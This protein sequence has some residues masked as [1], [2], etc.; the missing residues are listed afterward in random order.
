V[1]VR[2]APFGLSLRVEDTAGGG[3]SIRLPKNLSAL[4]KAGLSRVPARRRVP[5]QRDARFSACLKRILLKQ[6]APPALSS[7]LSS[8]RREPVEWAW[9]FARIC[10]GTRGG[11]LNPCGR[12]FSRGVTARLAGAWRSRSTPRAHFVAADVSAASELLLS[13]HGFS[14]RGAGATRRIRSRV[15][16]PCHI[17]T[18]HRYS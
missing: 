12:I 3:I 6:D 7:T 15:G 2:Q 10:N 13:W 17:R 18:M 5:L 4:L 8:D 16:N 11:A 1:A 14:T 9:A